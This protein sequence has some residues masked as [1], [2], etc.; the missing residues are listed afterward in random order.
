M[1]DNVGTHPVSAEQLDRAQKTPRDGG[2][3]KMEDIYRL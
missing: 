2:A 3:K 1:E